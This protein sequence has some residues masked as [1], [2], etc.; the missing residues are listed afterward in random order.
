VLEGGRQTTAT[1]LA[2]TLL[3]LPLAAD[4]LLLLLGCK[5]MNDLAGHMF[6]EQTLNTAEALYVC[7]CLGPGTNRPSSRLTTP[8]SP[9]I[10]QPTLTIV[11]VC[12]GRFYPPPP[13]HPHPPHPQLPPV[14]GIIA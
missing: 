9:A 1:N 12:I 2:T 8:H 3:P 14:P 4:A 13:S 6:W 7:A 11:D 10:R 5:M